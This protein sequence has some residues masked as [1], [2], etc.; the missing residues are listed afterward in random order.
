MGRG[1]GKMMGFSHVTV[2]RDR[3]GKVRYRYRRKGCK[4]VY[5]PG[6][7]GSPEF[8]AAYELA[9]AGV[10]TKIEVGASR[11]VPGTMNALAVAIYNS[12]E[13]SQ[14]AATTQGTYRG[15]MERIRT[16]MGTLPI[17]GFT[18]ERILALRDKRRDTPSAANNFVKILRWMMNFAV[19]RKLRPDNPCVG[20][21]PIK[22]V[23]DG[24][25]TWSEA[26]VKQYEDFWPVGTRE[27]KAF[28]LLLFTVQRSGDV[29]QM[30]RQHSKAGR[31]DFKQQ[32]TGT[33]MSLPVV[34][35]L[36]QSLDTVD[37]AQMLYIVTQFGVGY[38]AGGFGN[39][40]NGSARKAGLVKC[41]AH[42]LR[43]TGATRLAD[44]GF[45]ESVIMAWTGHKTP[46]EV[47]R[48]TSKRNQS[49]LADMA[50]ETVEIGTD[51]EQAAANL[52]N[53]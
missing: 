19:D 41:T 5:L 50:V 38:T 15:I 35:S 10:S 28:D 40:F 52:K 8:A 48:Y 29:R 11:T 20:I 24:W 6:L 25:K 47:L 14:M 49:R 17:K 27:R 16:D 13:W 23:S 46:K 22:I 12:A 39:W 1:A 34:P 33:A 7:P 32:K 43:K 2:M 42:G 3:H 44:K 21:K 9:T 36:K 26:E 4:T 37:D 30:G 45:S 51:E 31:L 53:G 18:S